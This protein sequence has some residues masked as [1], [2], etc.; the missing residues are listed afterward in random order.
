MKLFKF[1]FISISALIGTF[2]FLRAIKT[3]KNYKKSIKVLEKQAL[4]KPAE[5]NEAENRV[6]S[7]ALPDKLVYSRK[8]IESLL[9]NTEKLLLE[10]KFLKDTLNRMPYF[11]YDFFY[12]KR[13]NSI[14][15]IYLSQRVIYLALVMKL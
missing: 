2:A 12:Q 3:C 6:K 4:Q 14:F 8:E 11:I 9:T 10:L 15:R 5:I 7:T 1:Y 13:F